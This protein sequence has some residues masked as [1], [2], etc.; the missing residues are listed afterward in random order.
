MSRIYTNNITSE[1]GRSIDIETGVIASGVI[2]ATSFSGDAVGLTGI[3]V[4]SIRDGG[5]TVRVEA[6]TS[7]AVVSGVLT[8]TTLS[9][10]TLS[11]T[12]ADVTTV[13]SGGSITAASFYGDGSGLVF[14]PKIIAYDPGAL[15]TGVAVDNNITFTFDQN[16]YFSGTGTINIRQ[17]SASGTIVESFTISSGTPG[18]GLSIVDTQLIINPTSDLVGNTA[19][20]V[21]LP[22]EGIANLAGTY[23]PGSS[24]YNFQ[25]VSIASTF[26]MSGGDFTFTRV[27]PTSPTGYYKYH[28]FNSSGPLV[29]NA[30]ATEAEDF[31]FMMIAGGGAGSGR[32]PSYPGVG[33]GGGGGAGGYVARTGPTLGLPH[34]SYTVTIGGA[35][36]PTSSPWYEG[37]PGTESKVENPNITLS[38]A[39]GGAGAPS[40][41]PNNPK[42]GQSGGSGGG[43]FAYAVN[44]D[45]TTG[46]GG[47]GVPGQGYPGGIGKN[48]AAIHSYPHSPTSPVGPPWSSLAGGGGGAGGAGG[49]ASGYNYP[50]VAPSYGPTNRVLKYAG[51]GGPGASN[52]NFTISDFA[53]YVPL[54]IMPLD[55]LSRVGPT[56]LYGGGGG[57]GSQP[58]PYGS[59]AG[60]AGPGGGGFGDPGNISPS[61]RPYYPTQYPG[62]PNSPTS[63][64]VNAIANMGGGGGGSDGGSSGQGGSGIVLIRYAV[65]I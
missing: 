23:Y 61:V 50:P 9:A 22:S 57:G 24:N 14:A 44:Y 41:P 33:A 20:Y 48:A 53:G 36:T 56:G 38:V 30:D 63:S 39:G 10:T 17:G 42:V 55:F 58:G 43:G 15:S 19:Y 62:T 28:I 31:A 45:P 18:A 51:P 59:A 26:T 1:S 32:S 37:T 65:T 21:T 25:T 60:F 12:T 34:G 13:S 29:M 27:S 3:A 49:D 4:T 5:N 8:S 54:P 46:P 6:N 7:G 11:V 52:T 35:G 16:I 40:R 2:T 47:L 64:P